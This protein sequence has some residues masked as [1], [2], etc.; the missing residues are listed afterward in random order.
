[1]SPIFYSTGMSDGVESGRGCEAAGRDGAGLAR[2]IGTDY[3]KLI[4]TLTLYLERLVL[5]KKPR[6]SIFTVKVLSL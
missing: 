3:S 5:Y 6:K 4:H 2:M 1:M